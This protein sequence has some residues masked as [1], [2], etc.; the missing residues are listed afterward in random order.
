MNDIDLKLREKIK[1]LDEI[2]KMIKIP[3][4]QQYQQCSP[5][6]EINTKHG[7][8]NPN[9]KSFDRYS[10]SNMSNDLDYPL[11]QQKGVV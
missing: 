7:T 8:R 4:Y 3:Q 2:D 6:A 5:C 11:Q 10:N 9:N 1:M